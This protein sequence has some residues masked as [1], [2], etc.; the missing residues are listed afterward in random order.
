MGHQAR[1][2]HQGDVPN[3]R[4]KTL[5]VFLCR[6]RIGNR[7]ARQPKTTDCALLSELDKSPGA[8][9]A[10]VTNARDRP[11]MLSA[12]ATSLVGSK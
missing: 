4:P 11:H 2:A 7:D 9:V 5:N 10:S 3:A 12:R 1:Q 6:E 8:T